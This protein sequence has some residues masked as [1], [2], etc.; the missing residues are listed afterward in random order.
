MLVY[1]EEISSVPI[2][3]GP[4]DGILKTRDYFQN[5]NINIAFQLNIFYLI[6]KIPLNTCTA[7]VADVIW[8]YLKNQIL[9]TPLG[10]N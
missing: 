2:C 3:N 10:E 1:V 9:Y 7:T 8:L 5:I 4:D 6:Y